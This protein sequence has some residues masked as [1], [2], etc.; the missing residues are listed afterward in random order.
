ML[1]LRCCSRTS[2]VSSRFFGEALQAI[3]D[4]MHAMRVELVA[5]IDGVAG[6]VAVL[7]TTSPTLRCA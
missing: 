5:K 4:E 2:E 1:T 3:R 6:D 7:K